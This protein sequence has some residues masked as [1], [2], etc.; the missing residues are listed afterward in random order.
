MVFPISRF[1]CM[2]PVQNDLKLLGVKPLEPDHYNIHTPQ[3]PK[4]GTKQ[5]IVD[6]SWGASF[7][8]KE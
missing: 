5:A 4:D 6:K 8:C 3:L 2:D 7:C 1:L